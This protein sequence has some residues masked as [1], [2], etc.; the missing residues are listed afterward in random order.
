MIDCDN[1]QGTKEVMMMQEWRLQN[2]FLE[3]NGAVLKMRQFLPNESL[4]EEILRLEGVVIAKEAEL[5]FKKEK[6][7]K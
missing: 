5:R 6:Y 2:V 4:S 3:R 1:R 7:G